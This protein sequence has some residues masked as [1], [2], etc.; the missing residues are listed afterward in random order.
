MNFC[1]LRSEA[2]TAVKGLI[3]G[4]RGYKGVLGLVDGYKHFR[5][6]YHLHLPGDITLKME[7]ICSSETLVTTYNTT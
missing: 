7:V 2:L 4:L 6:M 3:L 1:I 5:G